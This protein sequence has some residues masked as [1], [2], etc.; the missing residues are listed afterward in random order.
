MSR[1]IVVATGNRHKIE[2]IS[3]ILAPLGIETVGIA[4]MGGMPEVVEDGD[5]FEANAV[6]KAREVAAAIGAPV[7]ADD[8]GLA[9]AALDGRPGVY[10]ARYAGADASDADNVRKLLAEMAE[11][12]SR[13]AKFVCVIAVA[14]E[15]GELLGTARGE[16]PGRIIDAPRGRGGFGYD[17]IFVPEG[18]DLTFAELPAAVKNS[19]SH[20]GEA[21]RRLV[22]GDMLKTL[23]DT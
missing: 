21:L 16:V 19:L 8:S 1:R 15:T 14:R 17:P 23:C 10:S 11:C 13:A 2:E 7:L 20:R 6:K 12:R 4:E 18:Y 5:T 22:A 3:A 9:V